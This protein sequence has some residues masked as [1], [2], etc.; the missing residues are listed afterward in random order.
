MGA[1]FAG[2]GHHWLQASSGDEAD[3][4]RMRLL[5]GC[6]AIGGAARLG[7]RLTLRRLHRFL[8]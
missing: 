2:Y 5:A 1:T 3:L 4:A 6:M 7:T 8:T